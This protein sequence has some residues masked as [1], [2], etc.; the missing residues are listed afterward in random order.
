MCGVKSN[1][2]KAACVSTFDCNS[3]KYSLRQQ[4]YISPPLAPTYPSVILSV[5]KLISTI[6]DDAILDP[7]ASYGRGGVKKWFSLLW[8]VTS[9]SVAD[10]RTTV[11]STYL[12]KM[13]RDTDTIALIPNR[14]LSFPASYSIT[15]TL[16]NR[17][18]RTSAFNIIFSTASIAGSL[19]HPQVRILGSQLQSYRWKEIVFFANVTFPLC[20]KQNFSNSFSYTWKVYEDINYIPSIQSFSVDPRFFKIAPYSLKASTVYTVAVYVSVRNHRYSY[21]DSV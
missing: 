20:R 4:L 3:F 21:S 15:L 12:N 18:L 9:M 1:V 19:V 16:T 8:S 13:F 17:F 5:S 2:I 10:N 7:T 6:C 14:L 11:I